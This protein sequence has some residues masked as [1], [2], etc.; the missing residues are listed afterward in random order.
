M[1][2]APRLCYVQ[3]KQVEIHVE[4]N[5]LPS[6]QD[7]LLRGLTL[8]VT[9]SLIAVDRIPGTINNWDLPSGSLRRRWR[10]H[11]QKKS[12]TLN[13]P[14]KI[15]QKKFTLTSSSGFTARFITHIKSIKG[16]KTQLCPFSSA[17]V[18]RPSCLSGSSLLP[19]TF[20]SWGTCFH[21]GIFLYL[22]AKFLKS[23]WANSVVGLDRLRWYRAV[24]R[25]YHCF[26]PPSSLASSAPLLVVCWTTSSNVR[27]PPPSYPCTAFFNEESLSPRPDT[28]DPQHQVECS[29]D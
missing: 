1:D 29:W 11:L 22:S 23:L 4:Y 18:Y 19:T 26:L 2:S 28:V 6:P 10:I 24:C 27:P 21:Y 9:I 7:S 5:Y 20:N 8:R 15:W 13:V 17:D 25:L 14:T 16:N 12:R 3:L